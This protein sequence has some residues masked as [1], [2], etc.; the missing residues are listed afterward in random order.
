MSVVAVDDDNE[1]DD[2]DIF[3][4][5]PPSTTTIALPPTTNT[6]GKSIQGG[7]LSVID[8]SRRVR[9]GY[10]PG[11]APQLPLILN[12]YEAFATVIQI[13]AGEDVCSRALLL[14]PNRLG[15][16]VGVKHFYKTSTK[17]FYKTSTK[18]FYKTSTSLPLCRRPHH[19]LDC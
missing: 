4:A 9:W 10:I 15:W 5:P 19:K 8:M 14:E 12:P 2:N 7:E 18:H 17:H 11:T 13:D 1:N 16:G 6:E 3:T